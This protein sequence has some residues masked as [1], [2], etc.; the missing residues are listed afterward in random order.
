MGTTTVK[1]LI[2][3]L[4]KSIEEGSIKGCSEVTYSHFTNQQSGNHC[5]EFNIDFL[6]DTVEED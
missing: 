3:I 1:Q 5:Y 6:W 4:N 2:E